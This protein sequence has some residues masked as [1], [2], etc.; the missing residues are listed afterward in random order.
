M[1]LTMQVRVQGGRGGDGSR[2]R[3]WR[4]CGEG[5]MRDDPNNI[6]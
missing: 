3:G 4:G 6:V 5:S 2:S 1:A